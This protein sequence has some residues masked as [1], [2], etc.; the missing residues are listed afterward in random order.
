V[1]AQRFDLNLPVWYRS[2]D[3]TEWH[4]GVTEKVSATGAL[5]RVEESLPSAQPVHLVI[6]LPSA[7]G[8]LIG[9]G[10]LVRTDDADGHA[11]GTFAIGVGQFH[12]RSK[13]VLKRIA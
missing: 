13:A 4:A 3:E 12:I 8:C 9:T 5:I 6:A 11:A 7:A 2:A 1:R 10:R